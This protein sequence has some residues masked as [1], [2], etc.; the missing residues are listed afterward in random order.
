MIFPRFPVPDNALGVGPTRSWTSVGKWAGRLKMSHEMADDI[1][2]K[3]RLYSLVVLLTS[4]VNAGAAERYEA[5]NGIRGL[6]MGGA[7]IATVNDETALMI[8][9]AA[10]GKLRDYFVTLVDPEL[11]IGAETEQI[12]GTKIMDVTD[13]QK[14]LDLTL[15]NPGRR[16]HTRAQVFPSIVVPNFG[17][18]VFAKNEVN[19]EYNDQDETFTYH[20][21]K[22]FAAVLGVNFRLFNGI[23]KLGANARAT[24]RTE[25]M[26]DDLDPTSTD[27]DYKELASEGLGV[28]SDAGVIIT[29]PIAYLPMLAAVYRDVGAT[30][31]DL[32]DGM[33]MKTEERPV[34]TKGTLDAAIALHPI[35]GKRFRSTW[36]AELRDVMTDDKEETLM[37]RLHGGFEF[38]YADALFVRGGMNQGYWT[39]GLELAIVN[40][41][42]QAASYGEEIGVESEKREDRRYVVKF[43]FRF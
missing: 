43:A 3:I 35:V 34:T 22:D 4:A 39:A 20:Y 36:T 33:L 40:Y 16:L 27:L 8:N 2:M 21:R 13:P 12:T 30:S 41:Q 5:Y 26:R 24:N 17:F 18:G 10:L 9:P 25:I 14:T 15:T 6:G 23:I 31:Y 42:F 1:P 28:G 7:A 29:A 32:R 37:R 11:D 19:A 38:N